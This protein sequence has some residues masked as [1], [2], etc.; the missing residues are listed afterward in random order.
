MSNACPLRCGINL[1]NEGDIR[2]HINKNC[3]K[4]VLIKDKF[5]FC[6]SNYY[7]IVKKKE[8]KNHC[9]KC[10]LKYLN[11]EEVDQMKFVKNMKVL[12]FF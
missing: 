7:V 2:N 3:A 1:L 5:E 4:L 11:I 10:K 8:K 12:F 6:E 9:E